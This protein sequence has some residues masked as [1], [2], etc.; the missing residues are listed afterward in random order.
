MPSALPRFGGFSRRI[1]GNESGSFS[2]RASV[3][4]FTNSRTSPSRVGSAGCKVCGPARMSSRA[5]CR[6][7]TVEYCIATRWEIWWLRLSW[8]IRPPRGYGECSSAATN[9]LRWWK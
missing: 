1:G 6:S 7:S 8:T 2:R 9:R 5:W 3:K 4:P